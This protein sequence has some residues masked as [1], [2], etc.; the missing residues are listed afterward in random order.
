MIIEAQHKTMK[1][2]IIVMVL[3]RRPL[4]ACGAVD[5]DNCAKMLF[6]PRRACFCSGRLLIEERYNTSS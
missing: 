6:T 2:I 3:A 1:R 5:L 4:E